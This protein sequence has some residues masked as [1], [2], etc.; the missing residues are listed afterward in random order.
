MKAGR[1][2]RDA[3]GLG[4]KGFA[5]ALLLSA[6]AHLPAAYL[7]SNVGLIPFSPAIVYATQ[8]MIVMGIVGR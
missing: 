2:A 7:R 3:H 8:I 4:A 6:M 5:L 1:T